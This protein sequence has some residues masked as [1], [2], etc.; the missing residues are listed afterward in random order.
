[1]GWYWKAALAALSVVLLIKLAQ[2]G[3]RQL[4]GMVAAL[5]TTTAPALLWL[6]DER[7][8]AF[9]AQA[10][11]ASVG[12]CAMLAAFALAYAH[13]ARRRGAVG[14]LVIALAASAL[15]ALPAMAA[16][17]SL[18]AS[19]GLAL[20][21]AAI[22]A[23]ALPRGLPAVLSAKPL[24]ASVS[25]L[26][27]GAIAALAAVASPSLGSLGAGIVASMPVSGAALAA[28]AHVAQGAGGAH[29]FL[30][31]YVRGL[32]A[33]MTFGAVF[34]LAV[35]P[36]GAWSAAV[37]AGLAATALVVVSPGADAARPPSIARQRSLRSRS[38]PR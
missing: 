20:V 24:P 6:A 17:G 34:A 1:M 35:S 22:A 9:A 12:A 21:T 10:A 27:S 2:R 13:A 26:L 25:G 31:G 15:A 38:A 32:L 7:G 11:V 4:A 14:A 16:S 36:C 18:A 30:A 37:L 3:G 5:P 8:P 19:A 33:R 23:R 28:N 29:H